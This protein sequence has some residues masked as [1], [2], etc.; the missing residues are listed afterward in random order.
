M[1]SLML[2]NQ[3]INFPCMVA[4]NLSFLNR[5]E[6]LGFEVSDSNYF[7]FSQPQAL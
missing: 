5:I 2:L 7:L 3:I 1:F 4:I 6:Y